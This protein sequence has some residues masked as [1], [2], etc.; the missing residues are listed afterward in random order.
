M[1]EEARKPRG[2]NLLE[3]QGHPT[4]AGPETAR[5]RDV[6]R[7]VCTCP[8]ASTGI[9]G[10]GRWWGG[11]GGTNHPNLPMTYGAA[12]DAG[13][14]VQKP[15]QDRVPIEGREDVLR[16]RS[17]WESGNGLAR[18]MIMALKVA[19]LCFSEHFTTLGIFTV[20]MWTG[21]FNQVFRS[22]QPLPTRPHGTT[23]LSLKCS[24][25]HSEP[26]WLVGHSRARYFSGPNFGGCAISAECD[27]GPA[28]P[29]EHLLIFQVFGSRQKP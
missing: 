17:E 18:G 19:R 14:S 2:Q 3:A 9:L 7:S 24:E 25:S 4:S 29:S 27:R 22:A 23:K 28:L 16:M 12:P 8:S 21:G 11:G 26:P 15:G 10:V 1:K 6:N 20:R 5:V 13:L